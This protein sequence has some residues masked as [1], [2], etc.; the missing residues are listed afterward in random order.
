MRQIM[1]DPARYEDGSKE[2]IL[3]G[4]CR[5]CGDWQIIRPLPISELVETEAMFIKERC[6]RCGVWEVL[7]GTPARDRIFFRDARWGWFGLLVVILGAALA[8]R[9]HAV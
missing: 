1:E 2:P 8:A 3:N 9:F 6:P 7:G 5:R 4:S